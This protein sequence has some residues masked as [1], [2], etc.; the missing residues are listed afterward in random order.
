MRGSVVVQ[1]HRS[2]TSK[3]SLVRAM[4]S[5]IGLGS[6]VGG[7]EEE[8]RERASSVFR[9]YCTLENHWNTIHKV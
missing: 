7:R 1:L 8:H 3:A 2:C 9:R 6:V 4:N 5:P